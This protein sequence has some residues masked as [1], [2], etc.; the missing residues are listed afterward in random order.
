MSSHPCCV[1]LGDDLARYGFANDHPFGPMRHQV[2]AQEF[3]RQSLQEKVDILVP[4]SINQ[5]ILELFHNHEYVE[6][7]KQQSILGTGYLDQGDTPA[8][9]GMYEAASFVVGTVC[10]AID[11][12]MRKEYQRSFIPIAGLHH[13]RRHI[14]AGFCVFNDCGVA[15]EY[16]RHQHNI[17]RI[18]YVDIDAHH[19]DGVFYSFED[20]PELIFADLHEDGHFLYPGTGAATETGKGKAIGTKLN[21]PMPPH[22][23][24]NAFMQAWESVEEFLLKH[25]ADFILL[26]CGAD[27]IKGDPITHMEY[28]EQ[29][30]AH[31][32]KRLSALADQLC[33]G[34][35]IAM[36]GGG[37]NHQN[38]AKT[39]AA[40]VASMV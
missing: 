39:W 4:Q 8:F 7:V 17:Q 20:D 15:V 31:A 26:Q 22:A 24:D 36:G 34:R 9:I 25:G 30:H 13:A 3:Y 37:Y 21:I 28:T 11:R 12:I 2:F 1:Y 6:Q 38:I 5:N 14:A 27:S 23:D 35:L 29:A 33:Q 10:D 16:L 32:T 18:A 40:V 19:G